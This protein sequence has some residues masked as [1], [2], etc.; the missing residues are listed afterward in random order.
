MM[1]MRK[2]ILTLQVKKILQEDVWVEG[3]RV[4]YCARKREITSKGRFEM[5]NLNKLNITIV[6]EKKRN[7]HLIKATDSNVME[8]FSASVFM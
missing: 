7:R 4:A 1:C 5:I 6:G 3:R 8:T 2:L